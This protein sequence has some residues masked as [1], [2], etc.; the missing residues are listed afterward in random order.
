MAKKG[1][2]ASGAGM[3]YRFAHEVAVGDY[4]VFPSK[5]D[6]QINIGI[7]EGGYEYHP[8]RTE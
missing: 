5:I 2:I 3:L 4:I 8:K 7:V 6:C 1:S